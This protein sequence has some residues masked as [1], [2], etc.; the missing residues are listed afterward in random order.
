MSEINW[1]LAPEGAERLVQTSSYVTWSKASELWNYHDACWRE[2]TAPWRAIATRPSEQAKTVAD[3]G[4]KWTHVTA[5]DEECKI[6]VS[7][8]DKFGC[9]VILKKDWGYSEYAL[10]KLEPIKPKMTEDA[11]KAV[12]RFAYSL[13]DKDSYDLVSEVNSF[14][15]YHEII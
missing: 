9:V 5:E 13:M 2:S 12:E 14:R 15:E 4:E 3:E 10:S 6:V 1:D 11:M 8:Q 7:K